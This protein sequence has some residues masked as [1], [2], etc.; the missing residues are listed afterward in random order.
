[1]LYIITTNSKQLGQLKQEKTLHRSRTCTFFNPIHWKTLHCVIHCYTLLPGFVLKPFRFFLPS[2]YR[3]PDPGDPGNEG[4]SVRGRRAGSGP[5]FY[6][7]LWPGDLRGQWQSLCWLCHLHRCQ[8][9]GGC[10]YSQTRLWIFIM[11]FITL[12][13]QVVAVC[14]SGIGYLWPIGKMSEGNIKYPFVTNIC[15]EA[16]NCRV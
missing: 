8:W 2:R 16:F 9:T 14:W 13:F 3:G 11:F 4:F 12:F 7:L 1:M 15:L 10:K 6:W 5:W